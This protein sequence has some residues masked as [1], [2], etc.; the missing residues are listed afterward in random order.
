MKNSKRNRARAIAY[1]ES[2]LPTAPVLSKY[3]RK[4]R[5]APELEATV[6]AEARQALAAHFKGD[7]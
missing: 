4:S 5:G 2:R 3:A 1:A 6:T 7:E